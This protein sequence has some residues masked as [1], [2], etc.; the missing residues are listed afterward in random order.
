LI[1]NGGA[2]G[3]LALLARG[4]RAKASRCRRQRGQ[5]TV[6][7]FGLTYLEAGFLGPRLDQIIDMK[8]ALGEAGARGAII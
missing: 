7:P 8:H 4:S 2:A 3:G 1:G 6:H 5:R